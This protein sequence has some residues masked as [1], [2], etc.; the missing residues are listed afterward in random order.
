MCARSQFVRK[1]SSGQVPWVG[2]CSSPF[3]LCVKTSKRPGG[4]GC[5]SMGLELG[6]NGLCLV[7]AGLPR[8]SG[9]T[10]HPKGATWHGEH[11][12]LCCSRMGSSTMPLGRSLHAST[13]V[14]PC[15]A[16]QSPHTVPHMTRGVCRAPRCSRP[17][18]LP[19]RATQGGHSSPGPR[20]V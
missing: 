18:R 4:G 2:W 16:G 10:R 20:R 13:V 17:A 3:L 6:E 9:T 19:G 1:L 12:G 5:I 11:M 8:L 14:T 7:L 15:Q